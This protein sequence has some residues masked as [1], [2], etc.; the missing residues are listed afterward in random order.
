MKL[1]ISS[2][3]AKASSSEMLPTIACFDKQ[4][5]DRL[6]SIIENLMKNREKNTGK[7]QYIQPM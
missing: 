2:V 5:E 7:L 1:Y 3:H 4:R 6:T